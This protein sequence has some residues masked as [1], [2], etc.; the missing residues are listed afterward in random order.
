MR[1]CH[2][3]KSTCATGPPINSLVGEL[4]IVCVRPGLKLC[5]K[6][7]DMGE[8]L[9]MQRCHFSYFLLGFPYSLTLSLY[10]RLARFTN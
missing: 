6:P 1:H 10:T 2:F 5:P 9:N 3:L 4:L 8:K 7:C